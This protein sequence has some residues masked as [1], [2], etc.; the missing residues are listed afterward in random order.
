LLFVDQLSHRL[1][2][3]ADRIYE[4]ENLSLFIAIVLEFFIDQEIENGE[5]A[6]DVLEGEIDF[7]T[8]LM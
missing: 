3:I 5:Q 1:D 7:L 2:L 6:F 8:S 4:D